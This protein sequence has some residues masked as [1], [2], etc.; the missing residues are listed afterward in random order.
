MSSASERCGGGDVTPA[1]RSTLEI[2][3]VCCAIKRL[4]VERYSSG[5]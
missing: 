3:K 5:F 1:T 2:N 4:K